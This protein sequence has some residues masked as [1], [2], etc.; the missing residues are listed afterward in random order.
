MRPA[1]TP[2]SKPHDAPDD[3]Q[4]IDVLASDFLARYRDGDRPTIEEY[5]RRHPEFGD[6]IRRMFPL[7]ASLERIKLNEQLEVGGGA[8]MAGHSISQLGDFRIL[9]E[10]GRGG[11]GIVFEARQE[12]LGRNVAIKVLPKHSLLDDEAMRRYRREAQAAAAMHHANIVPV[13]GTGES[14]GSQYLVMQ[15]I[16]GDS[17]D[18]IISDFPDVPCREV[19][20]L[21]Q[22]IA[23]AIA[24]A[25]AGGVLHRDI[26]PANI[27][28]EESGTAQITD[29]G[30]AKNLSDD[31]TTTG[32][33]SGSLR[34][35]APERFAGVSNESGDIY[36]IGITI[37]ELLVGRPAFDATDAEHLIGLITQGRLKPVHLIRPEIPID[38]ATIV[39][40]AIHVDPLQR[41]PSAAEL[42]DDLRRYLADEP[43]KARRT[44]MV[45]RFIRWTRRNP[46]LAGALATTVLALVSATLISNIAFFMT[47]A[48]NRRTA[49]ALKASEDTVDLALKSLD[50]VVEIVSHSPTSANL[51]VGG[52]FGDDVLPNVGVEPSPS[53]AQILER[54]QPIYERLSR[55]SPS[56]RD[57]IL[58]RVDSSIKLARM[59]HM[60]GRTPNSIMT[61]S[62]SLSLLNE[63]LLN[64]RGEATSIPSSDLQLQ[65]WLARL[66]NELGSM[67]AAEF[68]RDESIQNYQSAIQA[69]STF[70]M[71]NT[72]GQI[73]LARGHLNLGDRPPQLRSR[74]PF[75]R[76]QRDVDLNHINDAIGILAE[77]RGSPTHTKTIHIL[78]ASG[79]LA[80]SRT[81]R[82]PQRKRQ[83]LKAAL[84]ILRDQS[85]AAPDDQAVRF[86]LVEALSDVDLR[87]SH[88]PRQTA[89]ADE[90]LVEALREI[91]TLRAI[92]PDNTVY[93]ATEV[94]L[95][96]KLA[97]VA[98]TQSRLDD[99]EARLFDAIELQTRLINDWPEGVRHRCWRAMLYRSQAELY[100]EWKKPD[101][102]EFAIAQAKADVDAINPESADHP[103]AVRTR[104]AIRSVTN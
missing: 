78:Y 35:M 90:R 73:E 56:R 68:R 17:L 47:S 72:A 46:R 48:A 11:M 18:K 63:L 70:E 15:L 58:R 69:A 27:L 14:D 55:Q 93:L 82:D 97:S 39:G 8:T 19:A 50:G 9:R 3:C 95:H 21:G 24:H 71:T 66:H 43:I 2:A 31:A 100:R 80:R 26:K 94:H 77:L 96:H 75:G 60:L 29:F 99:A 6:S 12:S 49:E 62:T 64:E 88:S 4:L 38:L 36:G 85:K 53:S 104:Q 61:L 101:A 37:Y 102:A 51:V 42:R 83:D 32:A 89:N 74:E 76:E 98:R 16:R 81:L 87:G 1:S 40:K 34:Y 57:I 44:P 7:V 45:S 41:Y 33:V 92:N 67:H 59:Q 91:E 52:G 25:H 5:A 79:L 13:Y 103:L 10:I 86:K 23:D 28:V 30:L 54:L 65:L 20:K 84:S 22:Q